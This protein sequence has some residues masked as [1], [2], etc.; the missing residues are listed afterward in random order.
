MVIFAQYVYQKMSITTH[1]D[2]KVNA[3]P[4]PWME[5]TWIIPIDISLKL[6]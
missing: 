6:L 1:N 2:L 3:A 5:V 4:R